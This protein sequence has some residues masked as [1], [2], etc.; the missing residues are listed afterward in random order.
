MADF[1]ATG[2]LFMRPFQLGLLA[3]QQGRFGNAERGL[4]MIAEA[5]AWAERTNERWS[6]AELYRRKGDLLAGVARTE[7]AEGAYRRA[8]DVARYQG[9][10]AFELRASARLE[11][12]G[13]VRT[14]T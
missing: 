3:E 9:A 6:E 4:T 14:T 8:I 1:Q 12:L 11:D 2:S 10:K 13:R 5:L 7:E